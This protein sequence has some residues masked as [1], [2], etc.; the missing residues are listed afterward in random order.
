MRME[1]IITH[2]MIVASVVSSLAYAEDNQ[3]PI[4]DWEVAKSGSNM[5]SK[6]CQEFKI[7]STL[8][9]QF[10]TD[11]LI[12]IKDGKIQYEYY[13]SKYGINKVHPL[14]SITK[15]I[16]GVLLGIA[17]RDGRINLDQAVEEF[18]PNASRDNNFKKILIKNLLYLDTGFIWDEGK[19]DVLENPLVKMLYGSG[20]SDMV[21][22]ALSRKIITNGPGYKWNYSTAVP[23]ITMGV[24]KKVY[25]NDEYVESPWRNLFNPLGMKD[26]IFERDLKGTFIGGASAFATPRDLAKIGYLF[27]NNGVWNGEVILPPEWIKTMLTPSPGYLSPGTVITNIKDDGVFGGSIWLNRAV[28]KGLGKPYP[29]SPDD[30]YLAIGFMGQFLIMLPSQ[31]MIIVRTGHD[32]EFHNKLDAFVSRS[33]S[34]FYDPKY[35][36]GKVLPKESIKLSLEEIVRNIKNVFQANMLQGS[37]AKTVCSCHLASGIDIS[38]CLEKNHITF[39]KL[40]TKITVDKSFEYNGKISVLVRLSRLAKIFAQHS[41]KM[42]KAYYDPDHPEYGCTLK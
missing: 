21:N 41:T 42:A 32:R 11:G 10:L 39:S 18:Y 33:L 14:W 26:V 40:F 12:V 20:H 8:S 36:V 19:L 2:I 25:S 29:N 34:C 28:K 1:K 37:I 15:T 7:F 9:D 27:L 38:S 3:W 22:F 30:M 24:L 13:D 35:K 17:V 6:Q 16:T 23:T 4:P 31:N 5:N